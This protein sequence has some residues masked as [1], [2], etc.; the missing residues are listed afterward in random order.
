MTILIHYEKGS[1]RYV[2]ELRPKYEQVVQVCLSLQVQQA[3]AKKH[4]RMRVSGYVAHPFSYLLSSLL[5]IL[6]TLISM[7]KPKS[8]HVRNPCSVPPFIQGNNPVRVRS[9][10]SLSQRLSDVL[11]E[12]GTIHAT[13]HQRLVLLLFNPQFL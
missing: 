11:P 1:Y 2:K 13:L 9:A 4:G 12:I 6:F 8:T 10:S 5:K 3:R 7:K